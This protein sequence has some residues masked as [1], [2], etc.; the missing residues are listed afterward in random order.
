[1]SYAF[2]KNSPN[3]EEVT[4][5]NGV[6]YKYNGIKKSWEILNSGKTSLGSNSLHTLSHSKPRE[7]YGSTG[8]LLDPKRPVEEIIPLHQPIVEGSVRYVLN[9]ETEV[10]I[11]SKHCKHGRYTTDEPPYPKGW[12]DNGSCYF[13][14]HPS[15]MNLST[16]IVGDS[17]IF[18]ASNGSMYVAQ[19]RGRPELEDKTGWA[20]VQILK[21]F[22]HGPSDPSF[23]EGKTELKVYLADEK[24]NSKSHS[25]VVPRICGFEDRWLK[26][27][28]SLASREFSIT[29]SYTYKGSEISTSI[30]SS[31]GDLR[32]IK[33]FG[34][35]TGSIYNSD[36]PSV[37]TN[38]FGFISI[39]PPTGSSHKPSSIN[40]Y[41]QWNDY[42][43]NTLRKPYYLGMTASSQ[44]SVN[45]DKTYFMWELQLS[46]KESGSPTADYAYSVKHIGI[47]EGRETLS[48][49]TAKD[50]SL[51]EELSDE[52]DY[53][54]ANQMGNAMEEV[55]EMAKEDP[56]FKTLEMVK[57]EFQR[58]YG[59]KY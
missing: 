22:I 59:T 14:W 46:G 6:T 39:S 47:I 12:A 44:R 5:G 55:T 48:G 11:F 38:N 26:P 10:G 51:P 29:N 27:W 21:W 32:Q 33:L 43:K 15:N 41:N 8:T 45:S 17:I 4:L 54:T 42:A 40:D 37:Q 49:G 1:M 7:A 30:P 19:V 24:F 28:K 13:W 58:L 2:P 18:E 52:S 36:S 34:G 31:W 56:E 53:L 20:S 25:H 50:Y 35:Q 57:E 3:G 16:A 9:S 23:S